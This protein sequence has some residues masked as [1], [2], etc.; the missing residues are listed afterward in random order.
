MSHLG[1]GKELRVALQNRSRWDSEA[2][3]GFRYQSSFLRG[4]DGMQGS[5]RQITLLLSTGKLQI[6][7]FKT[8]F[9]GEVNIALRLGI[10]CWFA[11]LGLST[12]DSIFGPVVSFFNMGKWRNQ[13][14]RTLA[15][16][17]S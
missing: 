12:G 10:K 16:H 3:S 4:Q 9:L 14:F 1:N 15:S 6:D 5:V 8:L 2:N 13:D 11:D 7:W 17:L